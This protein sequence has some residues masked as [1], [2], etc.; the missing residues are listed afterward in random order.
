M[1]I[2]T[3]DINVLLGQRKQNFRESYKES[4]VKV[5]FDVRLTQCAL[6]TFN[7]FPSKILRRLFLSQSRTMGQ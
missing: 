6:L 1:K 4:N 5:D 3:S 7:L 2:L